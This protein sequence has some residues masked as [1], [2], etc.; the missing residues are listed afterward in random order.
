MQSLSRSP[1][2][3][4]RTSLPSRDVLQRQGDRDTVPYLPSPSLTPSTSDF[5]SSFD[6]DYPSAGLRAYRSRRSFQPSEDSGTEADDESNK[7]LKGLPAPPARPSQ[8]LRDSQGTKLD[9]G[10][11]TLNTPL[12]VDQVRGGSF[13]SYTQRRGDFGTKPQDSDAKKWKQKRRTELLRRILEVSL[14]VAVGIITIYNKSVLPAASEWRRELLC[15][16]VIVLLLLAIYFIRLVYY[17]NS[18]Q[19]P[20]QLTTLERVHIPVSVDPAPLLYPVFIPILVSCILL[21]QDSSPLLLN[22]ILSLASIPHQL[23]PFSDSTPG[24]QSIHWLTSVL[25]LIISENTSWE[26]GS[27]FSRPYK[28]RNGIINTLNPESLL[29]VYPLHQALLP[30]LR[31]LTTTSLLPAELQLLSSSLINI[32]LLSRSPQSIILHALLWRGGLCLFVFCQNVFRSSVELARIPSW[33]F[34]RAAELARTNSGSS[35]PLKPNYGYRLKNTNLLKTQSENLRFEI[36]DAESSDDIREPNSPIEDGRSS[37]LADCTQIAFERPRSHTLPTLATCDAADV[38]GVKGQRKR[39]KRILP[40]NVQ[41][42]LSLTP[43]QAACRRWLYATYAYIVTLAIIEIAIRRYVSRSALYGHEPIGWALGYIFG[44]LPLFRSMVVNLDLEDWIGLPDPGRSATKNSCGYGWVEHLRQDY[45]GEAN[46]RLLI[47]AFCLLVLIVGIAIVIRLSS[48][49]EVDTRRKVFHGMMV[50]MF[51]PITYIDPTYASFAL[52][53]ALAIFLLLDIFRASQLPPI[54][55]PLTYF[56]APYVD[57]RDHRGPVIVSHIFLLI[58][59]AI[60]LWLSLAGLPRTGTDPWK[61]W[62]VSIRDIGMVSGVI[63]VGMGDSAASLIGRRFGRRKWCWGGGK[64][65]EGS[66]AFAAAVT[67]GL[68]LSRLWLT[69][70]GWPGDSGD[71]WSTTVLK[72]GMAAIGASLTEAV[73]TG[74][75]DNVIVPITLWLL[76]QGLGI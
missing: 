21:P 67:T 70:G 47:S 14:I 58:G 23:I 61:G 41:S 63:C 22:I 52:S 60:P 5:E 44:D 50:S 48:V 36:S 9:E 7:L 31:Y 57:G 18:S 54:T 1:R 28:L 8:Y 65:I 66:V 29:L 49:V 75:N 51:L 20:Y 40:N 74:G 72:S 71:S 46:N 19:Q 27:H 25:P 42:L 12:I 17:V 59:C 3:Y 11:S 4:H 39:H 69:L 35:S 37:D 73:L 26:L 2:P 34:R 55:K 76:V 15:H 62:D 6:R 32:L 68:C 64:S 30:T 16:I 13:E 24:L 38:S 43:T 10:T 53:L 33:R 56:L 45:F